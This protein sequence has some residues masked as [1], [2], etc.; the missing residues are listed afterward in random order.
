MN[1]QKRR[2]DMSWPAMGSRALWKR[3]IGGRRKLFFAF[4]EHGTIMAAN[5]LNSP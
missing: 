2:R 4:T 1:T 3:K 5:V